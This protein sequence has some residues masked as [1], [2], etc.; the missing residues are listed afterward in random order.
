VSVDG[1]LTV[2]TSKVVVGPPVG[3]STTGQEAEGPH[4]AD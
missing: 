1:I 4:C 3:T 2:D